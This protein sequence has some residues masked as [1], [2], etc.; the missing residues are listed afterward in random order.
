MYTNISLYILWN[1]WNA[2]ILHI[3]CQ[4]CIYSRIMFVNQLN[5]SE[6]IRDDSENTPCCCIVYDTI[7]SALAM[8][9]GKSMSPYNIHT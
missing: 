2:I 7:S 1:G 9:G 6:N 4:S 3:N 5:D 8:S